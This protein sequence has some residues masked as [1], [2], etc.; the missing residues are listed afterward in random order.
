M[1]DPKLLD[2][3]RRVA[4]SL[5]YD[6]KW[7]MSIAIQGT[8][9][10]VNKIA[11]MGQSY[12]AG[13]HEAG[14]EKN[15][16]GP[17]ECGWNAQ[18]DCTAQDL[19]EEL[20]WA[21]S[22]LPDT[23]QM[24]KRQKTG[25][26]EQGTTADPN[27]PQAQDGIDKLVA[28]GP[29]WT[30][31]SN[32]EKTLLRWHLVVHE[33]AVGALKTVSLPFGQ[34]ELSTATTLLSTGGGNQ[35]L[36]TTQ[37]LAT[38]ASGAYG[39]DFNEPYL[40]QLRMTSPYNILKSLGTITTGATVSEPN[41]IGFFD[42]RYQYYVTNECNWGIRL[43]FGTPRVTAGG[44][45]GI[46]GEPQHH[47]L[48]IFWRYTSQDDP[49][50]HYAYTTSRTANQGSMS[51][52]VVN[53][54]SG[55]LAGDTATS[56]ALSTT[57]ATSY[58]LGSDDYERMNCWQ[59]KEVTFSTTHPTSVKLGGTYKLGQCKMDIKTLMPTDAA[60][61]QAIPT[62]EGMTLGRSTPAFPEILSLIIVN[63]AGTTPIAGVTV[64]FSMSFD[65]AHQ[66][67]WCDLRAAF[68]FP[69]PQINSANASNTQ[70]SDEQWFRRG[71]AYS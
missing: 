55:Q 21:Q 71:A 2:K 39:Y 66:V 68:K 34:T 1:V 32:T 70:Y 17:M 49:P 57:A 8:K 7:V 40:I 63:D 64:P 20:G 50:T 67:D 38:A 46:C 69:N 36:S 3:L 59:S 19:R 48:R 51:S 42:S 65:T 54:G 47:K 27:A 13:G 60:G 18:D 23:K 52:S 31:F 37:A 9:A 10:I 6:E 58:P 41:W 44:L 5:G 45:S 25:D 56:Q 33:P 4:R 61:P 14:N 11:E 35:T 53:Q 30:H 22:N 15:G 28:T 62:A 12:A 24:S 16:I 43:N 26:A 29:I